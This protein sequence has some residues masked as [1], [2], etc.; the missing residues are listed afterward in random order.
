MTDPLDF[1]L[2][3]NADIHKIK[4][5]IISLGYKVVNINQHYRHVVAQVTKDSNTYFFKMASR[6]GLNVFIENDFVWSRAAQELIQIQNWPLKVPKMYEFGTYEELNWLVSEFIDGEDGS[7]NQEVLELI[8][9]PMAQFIKIYMQSKTYVEL[10][11]D[12]AIKSDKRDFFLEKISAYE[13]NVGEHA[14]D[15]ISYLRENIND[16]TFAP[17]RG[18]LGPANIKKSLD[19]TLFL[20][21]SEYASSSNMKFY[22]V[23]YF[24]YRLYVN[25]KRKDLAA[26]FLEEFI[27]AYSMDALDKKAY[28]WAQVYKLLAGLNEA[29]EEPDCLPAINELRLR[30]RF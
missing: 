11:L 2:K 23:V 24:H 28:K 10:P 26:K 15:L 25:A 3:G 21:D 8:I 13:G 20:I 17:A 19:G 30:I 5:F 18:D 27:V 7:Q 6:Q 16:V 22:D 29:L 4:D 1:L 9:K 12:N 14:K